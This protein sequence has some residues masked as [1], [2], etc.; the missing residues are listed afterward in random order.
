MNLRRQRG[1]SLVTA[2][3][4]IT[5]VAALA[6]L[7]VQLGTTQRQAANFGALGDRAYAAAQSGLEWGAYRALTA[8][9]C[10]AATTFNLTEASLNGFRLQVR[11]RASALQNDCPGPQYRVYDITSFAQWR[12]FGNAEYVSRQL[13]KRFTNAPC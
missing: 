7:G 11:C 4:L 8:N 9:A 12:T 2:I 1:A 13:E 3:F 5:I 6:A 10:A